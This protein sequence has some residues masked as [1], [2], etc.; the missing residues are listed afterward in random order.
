M[1][2]FFYP[3]L[4]ST[5]IFGLMLSDIFFFFANTFQNKELTQC[6]TLKVQSENYRN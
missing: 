4:N 5:I 2:I 1:L 3:S 6:K